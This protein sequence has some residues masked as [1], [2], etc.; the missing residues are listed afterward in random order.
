[1]A[2]KVLRVTLAWKQAQERCGCGD[3]I[4]DDRWEDKDP[5][6]VV[7]AVSNSWKGFELVLELL[8]ESIELRIDT[9][10]CRI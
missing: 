1:M 3:G 7:G 5:I 9:R 8:L 10:T 6:L 2:R 4:D